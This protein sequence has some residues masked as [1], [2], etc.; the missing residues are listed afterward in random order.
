MNHR[1]DG[2]GGRGA[3]HRENAANNLPAVR[4]EQLRVR[5]N[6]KLYT[7]RRDGDDG[8]DE[9]DEDEEDSSAGRTDKHV[10]RHR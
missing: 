10:E 3:F 9:E 7:K 6:L 5:I 4:E 8:D 2:R 1:A